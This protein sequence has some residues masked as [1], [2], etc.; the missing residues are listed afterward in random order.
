MLKHFPWNQAV[1]VSRDR[2]LLEFKQEVDVALVQ[3]GI[4]SEPQTA[5]LISLGSVTYVPLLVF[6]RGKGLTS[7][8][9]LSGKRIAIDQEGS[10]TQELSLQLL[11]ANG[12]TPS[13]ENILLSP[14]GWQRQFSS[15]MVTSMP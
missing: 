15:S 7:L 13:V 11:V 14:E 4:A 9:Q 3:S 5:E 12:V 8:S 2:R 1:T 6:Y 10:G